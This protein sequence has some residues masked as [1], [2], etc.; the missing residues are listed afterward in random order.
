MRLIYRLITVIM[1]LAVWVAVGQAAT[2]EV[3]LPFADTTPQSKAMIAA[4]EGFRA[5]NPDVEIETVFNLGE[6][7]IIAAIAAGAAPD[8]VQLQG[9]W[10]IAWARRGLLEPLD[11]IVERAGINLNDFWPPL[12]SPATWDGRLYAMPWTTEIHFGLLWDKDLLEQAGAPSDTAPRTLPELDALHKKITRVTSDGKLE[13]VGFIPWE[14]GMPTNALHYF[15]GVFGG[16]MFD[17][18]AG[19]FSVND[20]GHVAALNWMVS[21]TEDFT[22]AQVAPFVPPVQKVGGGGLAMGLVV[23]SYVSWAQT[24]QPQARFGLG[25]VPPLTENGPRGD[26]LAGWGLGIPAGKPFKP[27]VWQFLKFLLTSPEG[28]A[29]TAAASSTLPSYRRTRVLQ[30]WANDPLLR[31]FVDIAYMAVRS[32][33]PV[34][35]P[36]VWVSTLDNAVRQ[37]LAGGNPQALLDE[38]NRLL[39]A[40]Y[41]EVVER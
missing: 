32:R 31:T 38:A 20:A 19:R 3:W 23:P 27:E 12:F 26:F 13:R 33:P 25:M 29:A 39:Q 7:K 8:I 16:V 24:Y 9:N 15:G 5:I 41:D 30:E 36:G 37:A 6:A 28:T 4:V 14:A 11:A 1:L 18:G 35:D 2:I 10:I 22:V 40:H 21:Y 34:P 17:P